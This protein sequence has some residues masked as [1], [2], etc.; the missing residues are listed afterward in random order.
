MPGCLNVFYMIYSNGYVFLF[1]AYYIYMAV[2]DHYSWVGSFFFNFADCKPLQKK[3]KHNT[4]R[5]N[6]QRAVIVEVYFLKE[7]MFSFRIV[8]GPPKI[9]TSQN[10]TIFEPTKKVPPSRCWPRFCVF[11][12]VVWIKFISF[13]PEKNLRRRLYIWLKS[14]WYGWEFRTC[15]PQFL[16]VSYEVITHF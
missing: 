11:F 5:D 12:P 9:S 1:M 3:L 14:I 15:N 8:F 7:N 10:P 6:W 16:G 13:G 2:Y 4:Q